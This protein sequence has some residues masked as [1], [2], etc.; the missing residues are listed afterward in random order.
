MEVGKRT[1]ENIKEV[2]SDFAQ[3]TG[4]RPPALI[5]TDDCSTYEQVL[6]EQYG[7]VVVPVSLAKYISVSNPGMMVCRNQMILT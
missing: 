5:T 4:G 3:R 7:E 1:R 2:V 6:L